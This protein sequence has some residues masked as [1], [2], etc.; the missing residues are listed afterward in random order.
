[1]TSFLQF[2][3]ILPHAELVQLRKGFRETLQIERLICLHGNHIRNM[4]VPTS[5][6]NPTSKHLADEI[7]IMYSPEKSNDRTAEEA[8]MLNWSYYICDCEAQGI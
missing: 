6:F 4:L 1:M 5:A 7:I 2:G 8:I 3:Y